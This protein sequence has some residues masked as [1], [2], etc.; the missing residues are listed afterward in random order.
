[1]PKNTTGTNPPTS[2]VE[3][4]CEHVL[5][6]EDE[7]MIRELVV[8][9]L[10]SLGYKVSEAS[11]GPTGLEIIRERADIDLLI[12]DIVMPGGM[13]GRDLAEEAMQLRPELRVLLTSGYSE[14]SDVRGDGTDRGFELLKKPYRRRELARRLRVMFEG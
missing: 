4:G 2:T 6:V 3:R 13:S 5:V 1:M 8:Q 7:D 11:D 14:D 12:S 10:V 9:Q